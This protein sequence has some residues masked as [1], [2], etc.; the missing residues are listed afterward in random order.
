MIVKSCKEDKRIKLQKQLNQGSVSTFFAQSL[1]DYL[2]GIGINSAELFAPDL[3]AEIQKYGARIPVAHWLMMFE[4]AI[5]YTADP[6][7]P[8][9]VAEH[10]QPKHLGML[11]FAVMSSQTFSDAI[12]IVLRYKY[13]LND[14]SEI[15]WVESGDLIELHWL[16]LFGSS[17]PIFMQHSLAAWAVMARQIFSHPETICNAHFSFKQPA[18]LDVYRRIFGGVLKF[19]EANTK[20]TFNKSILTLPITQSDPATHNLLMS[21]VEKT[22]QLLNQPN[23]LQ[24]LREYL[25]T[26]LASNQVSAAETA[27]A[28]GVSQRTLQ[29]QLHTYGMGY[30]QLLEQIRQEQATHYLSDTNFSLHEISFL[31]GYSEQ[32]PFQKA[33]KRWTGKSPGGVP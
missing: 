8:L 1:L 14:V 16:P 6:D 24:Q 30:R 18:Q 17:S 11:G 31:L 32:S 20:L 4:Q 29:Y 28:F 21:H 3:I 5:A 22:L 23:F 33:F 2:K 9:K 27:A 15:K 7:L 19:G 25:S 13:L 10:L 12:T 26:H